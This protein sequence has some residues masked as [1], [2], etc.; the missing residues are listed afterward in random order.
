MK[1]AILLLF[2]ACALRA[3]PFRLEP[4]D[5]RYIQFT[6]TRIPV[7]VDGRFRVLEG[8]PTVHMEI[9]ADSEY[10]RFNRGRDY[11]TLASSSNAREGEIR[12][13]VDER[14]RFDVVLMNDRGAPAA[15]VDLEVH[16]DVDP[17]ED[18]VARVL[19]PGRRLAVIL[20]SF[21]LFFAIV[22]WAAWRLLRATK[23]SSPSVSDS[24]D[25]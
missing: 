22:T 7:L 4:G 20:I 12:R 13:M 3:E 17:S 10:R 1:A 5:N 2:C 16:T 21:A 9:M 15:M 18:S 23:V 6:V 8:A 25:R 14:G 19:S 11:D 24:T